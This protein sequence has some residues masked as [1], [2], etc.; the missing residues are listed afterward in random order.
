MPKRKSLIAKRIARVRRI[1]M[2]PLALFVGF[3]PGVVHALPAV[4][5]Y[6]DSLTAASRAPQDT[7]YPAKLQALRPDLAIYNRGQNG[8]VTWNLARFDAAL[9]ERAWAWVIILM[10]T[11]DIDE[12][13]AY[14]PHDTFVN[15]WEMRRRAR[16][17]GADVI[18]LTP[19]PASCTGCEVRQVHTRGVAHELIHRELAGLPSHVVIADL[20]DQFTTV[21]WEWSQVSY[22]GLHMNET[23]RAL[24]ARFVSALVPRERP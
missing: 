6:G 3:L 23:G 12:N 5:C 4:M 8:D 16:A 20:R 11:N 7:S 13:S 17:N 14:T 10:G 24:L 2:L 19:S 15:L 9:A 21:P 1:R 22:D 18:L